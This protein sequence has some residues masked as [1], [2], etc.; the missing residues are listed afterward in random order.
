MSSGCDR[1]LSLKLYKTGNPESTHFCQ[2]YCPIL[3]DTGSKIY[4]IAESQFTQ[5]NQ[6]QCRLLDMLDNWNSFKG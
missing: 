2:G 1:G 3:K 6:D 5:V 4:G